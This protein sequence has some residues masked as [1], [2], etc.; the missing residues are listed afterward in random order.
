MKVYMVQF[1]LVM[2]KLKF[3]IGNVDFEFEESSEDNARSL[4]RFIT[5]LNEK[6]PMSAELQKLNIPVAPL[7]LVNS[8]SSEGL[9]PLPSAEGIASFIESRGLTFTTNR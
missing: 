3:G 8:K 1:R 9:I 2:R 4:S 7:K 5:F 6:A